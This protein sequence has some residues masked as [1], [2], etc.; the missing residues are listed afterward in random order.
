MFKE[1]KFHN[2]IKNHFLV[3]QYKKLTDI[4]YIK[5]SDRN[6]QKTNDF[7]SK[8]IL[9]DKRTGKNIIMNKSLKQDFNNY[10]NLVYLKTKELERLSKKNNLIPVFITLT[11]P[12]KYHPFVEINGKYTLNK[13]FNFIEIEER[14]NRGYKELNKIFRNFYLNVKNNRKNKDMKMIQINEPHGSLQVHKHRIL[15]IN[16][17]TYNSVLNTFNKIIEKYQLKQVVIDK[18]IENDEEVKIGK[19]TSRRGSSYIIK[20]LLKNF[21]SEELKKLDGWKKLHKIRM[22]SMSNLELNTE[23]FKKLYYSNKDLNIEIIKEIKRGKSKYNNLYQFYTENTNIRKVYIKKD[24]DTQ[25]IEKI[26]E[27][28]IIKKD[29]RFTITKIIE[30][31]DTFIEKKIVKEYDKTIKSIE[32]LRDIYY[33]NKYKKYRE[34][35]R[36]TKKENSKI[37]GKIYYI[38]LFYELPKTIKSKYYKNYNFKIYDN[39]LQ[40]NIVEKNTYI[41][42]KVKN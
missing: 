39:E 17:D 27:N 14:I 18:C 19:L 38:K 41:L 42:K 8:Y 36:I 23:F 2:N 9:E 29:N 22:F 32:G 34:F 28:I 3:K 11:L 35:Y 26:K 31:K 33:S 16:K 40:K 13:N 6:Y 37:F 21:K 5:K 24:K 4:E 7:L 10:K 30:I 1:L 15:Y 20:Y 25:K 12:S